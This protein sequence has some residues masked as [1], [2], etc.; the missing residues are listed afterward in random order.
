MLIYMYDQNK[1]HEMTDGRALG[2]GSFPS[3]RSRKF[4]IILIVLL[5]PHLT[6]PPPPSFSSSISRALR[7]PGG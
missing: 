7:I 3:H 6:T 5:P 2:L 4:L 1:G